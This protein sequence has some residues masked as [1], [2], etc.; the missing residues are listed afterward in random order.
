MRNILK[1]AS[2]ILVGCM[3]V[4]NVGC[5]RKGSRAWVE[6]K[7][8]NMEKVYPTE[9]LEDLFEKFSDGF[10]IRQ[11]RLVDGDDK[12]EGYN[13]VLELKGDKEN[14][15][16]KGNI[17]KYKVKIDFRPFTEVQGVTGK[18]LRAQKIELQ[19]HTAIILTS[20]NAVDHFF[21]VAEEMR[22]KVPDTMRYFCLSEAVA[23]YLQK[24]ITY[25][26]RKIY[27]GKKDFADLLPFLKKHKEEKFFFPTSEVLSPAIEK[28]L[29]D[30]KLNWKRGILF[31]TA[32]AD[33]SDLKD[34]KY[35]VI[36][37]FSP[38][39]VESLF[40]NFSDFK[41]G[42]TRIA[43][44]GA[45]TLKSAEEAGLRIDIQA[46]LPETPSMTMAL[47]KYLEKTNKR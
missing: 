13:Y 8:E 15:T 33:I 34:V 3:L 26:K 18:D 41:Q 1:K 47:D 10:Y 28:S 32:H 21:R 23:F 35:D 11:I 38:A 2:I 27:V 43:V 17:E 36:A 4:M 12:N 45:S 5:A 22:F 25:R 37:F 39:G 16:I 42:T 40:N 7:V 29:D 6:K 14:K 24:Y 19:N 31:K 30:L 46:P 9:N 44:F 20:R